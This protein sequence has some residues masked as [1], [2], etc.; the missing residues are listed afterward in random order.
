LTFCQQC[1]SHIQVSVLWEISR[2][3]VGGIIDFGDTAISDT[4]NDFRLEEDEEYGQ[5]SGFIVINYYNHTNMNLLM[6]KFH[7]RETYWSF[8]KIMCGREYGYDD[9]YKEGIHEI[10]T[11]NCDPGFTDITIHKN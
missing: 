6:K 7:I 2:N 11:M 5:E 4:D 8:E 3:R 1:S 10:K 9:W